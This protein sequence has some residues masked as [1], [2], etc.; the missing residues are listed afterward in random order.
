MRNVDPIH[1]RRVGS[2]LAKF[3]LRRPRKELGTKV[4]QGVI[5]DY[6]ATQPHLVTPLKDIVSK[7]AFQ[8][9]LPLAL[10]GKG[11]D[12]RDALIKD[13]SEVYHPYILNAIEEVVNGFLN[14]SS[15]SSLLPS[16]NKSGLPCAGSN[17]LTKCDKPLSERPVGY[18]LA[19]LGGLPAFPLG[20]ILSPLVLW[21][22]C[23]FKR[24]GERVQPRRFLYW[25]LVGFVVVPVNILFIGW[26][27][28]DLTT[29]A[30]QRPSILDL[31]EE[32]EDE[33]G[34]VDKR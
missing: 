8:A 18:V 5:S 34:G 12:K 3:V 10:T 1:L 19:V 31:L 9:L 6:A 4:L 25:A 26:L 28:S 11:V 16:S 17:S 22:L 20:P 21:F 33:E 23:H 14:T 32:I 13:I 24:G 30:E 7:A 2:D 29:E 15:A 27:A